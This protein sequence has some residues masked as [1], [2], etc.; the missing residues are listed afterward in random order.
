MIPQEAGFDRWRDVPKRIPLDDVASEQREIARAI[1]SLQTA[2]CVQVAQGIV[3]AIGLSAWPSPDNDG[4]WV[5]LP[6][7]ADL[8]EIARAIELEGAAARP[9][10]GVP[11]LL[12]PVQ[13]WFDLEEIDQ[14]ILCCLKVVHVLLGVHA[15]GTDL[16]VHLRQDAAC[17]WRAR[18]P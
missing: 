3:D 17:H 10:A 11:Y 18:S 1:A 14:T 13:P 4:V 12:L 5:E 2:I 8:G 7:G 15:P 9:A 6:P 16:D